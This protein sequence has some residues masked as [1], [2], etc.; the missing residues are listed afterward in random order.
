MLVQIMRI[1]IM[2]IW[3]GKRFY[4]PVHRQQWTPGI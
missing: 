3:V 1:R 4:H 2:I